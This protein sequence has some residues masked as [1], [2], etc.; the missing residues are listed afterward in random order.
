MSDIIQ[1]VYYYP[2]ES[3]NSFSLNG[4]PVRPEAI[5]AI[6]TYQPSGLIEIKVDL[7]LI[8][9]YY[10]TYLPQTVATI[11]VTPEAYVNFCNNYP[12]YVN[13]P[14]LT[15]MYN[16]CITPI[17]ENGIVYQTQNDY[18]SY[19]LQNNG[20]YFI[21]YSQLSG[22][23]NQGNNIA[24]TAINPVTE[25]GFTSENLYLLVYNQKAAQTT[26]PISTTTLTSQLTSSNQQLESGSNQNLGSNSKSLAETVT[27]GLTTAISS[28]LPTVNTD[29]VI[30]GI[31]GLGILGIIFAIKSD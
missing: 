11:Y 7:S 3:F 27:S 5:T 14:L 1:F 15:F 28:A 31:A 20:F 10:I 24:S 19:W 23:V 25:Y 30:L 9:D 17:R 18:V 26:T 13:Y 22:F 6:N 29:L 4:N 16:Y 12:E 21:P 2:P 8:G